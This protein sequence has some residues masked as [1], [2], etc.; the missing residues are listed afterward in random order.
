MLNFPVKNSHSFLNYDCKTSAMMNWSDAA[1]AYEQWRLQTNFSELINNDVTAIA[2]ESMLLT[3]GRDQVS[4]NLNIHLIM[5]YL[6]L[7]SN[8]E[9]NDS[10]LV[11]ECSLEPPDESDFKKLHKS[12]LL[13]D[14]ITIILLNLPRRVIHSLTN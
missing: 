3:G 5:N 2:E 9:G 4:Q 6:L 14:A 8:K 12:C 11:L 13:Q 7:L 10:G 1:A